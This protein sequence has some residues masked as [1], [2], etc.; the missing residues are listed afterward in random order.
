[1]QGVVRLPPDQ[2]ASARPTAEDGVEHRVWAGKPIPRVSPFPPFVILERRRPFRRSRSGIQHEES[3][4][5]QYLVISIW[6]LCHSFRWIS[7]AA[8]AL[9]SPGSSP[10]SRMTR[11][12]MAQSRTLLRTRNL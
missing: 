9:R 2:P 4:K 1:M 6:R 11:R 12:S 10:G 7:E 3:A 5:P 8:R